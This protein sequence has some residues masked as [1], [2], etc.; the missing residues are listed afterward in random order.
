MHDVSH[1]R[2]AAAVGRLKPAKPKEKLYRLVVAL[3]HAGMKSSLNVVLED[4]RSL[5]SLSELDAEDIRSEFGASFGDPGASSEPTELSALLRVTSPAA[6]LVLA[7][8][9]LLQMQSRSTRPS[10]NL[11][12]PTISFRMR[13]KHW[14]R[15]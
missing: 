15:P 12:L 14:K 8:H 3:R 11:T 2:V 5:S 9:L 7:V 10:R 1:E 13:L 4:V 6:T